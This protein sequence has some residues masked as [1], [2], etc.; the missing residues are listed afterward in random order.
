MLVMLYNL[1]GSKQ[2]WQLDDNL[3]NLQ[4]LELELI[5]LEHKIRACGLMLDA[6]QYHRRLLDKF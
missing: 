6:S 1:Q 3:L 4:E 2:L 5:Q